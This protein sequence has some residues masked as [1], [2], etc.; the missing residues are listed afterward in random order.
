MRSNTTDTVVTICNRFV[1]EGYKTT[2]VQSNTTF[3]DVVG[4]DEAKKELEDIVA[5]LKDPARCWGLG[6]RVRV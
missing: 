6:F 1:T 4:V 5:Y 3:A 2:E